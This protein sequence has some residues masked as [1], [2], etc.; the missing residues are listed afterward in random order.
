MRFHLP[1]S[2]NIFVIEVDRLEKDKIDGRFE[3]PDFGVG[4]KTNE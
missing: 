1:I 2:L 4:G 3:D